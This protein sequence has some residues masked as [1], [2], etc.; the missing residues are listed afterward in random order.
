[1]APPKFG[2]VIGFPGVPDTTDLVKKPDGGV[3]VYRDIC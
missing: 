1:M 2:F 3:A